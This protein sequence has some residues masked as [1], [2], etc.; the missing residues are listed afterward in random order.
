MMEELVVMRMRMP[1]LDRPALLLLLR[2]SRGV[3]F[4]S[5][6]LLHAME[7]GPLL[8]CANASR[9]GKRLQERDVVV[10]QEEEE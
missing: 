9:V 5:T 3:E 4:V 6:P 10:S 8:E 1:Q 2:C 7:M